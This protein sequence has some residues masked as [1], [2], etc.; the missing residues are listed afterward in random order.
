M[1]S[2]FIIFVVIALIS[3]LIALSITRPIMRLVQSMLE[4]AQGHLDVDIAHCDREDEIGSMN[5]AMVIFRD[6]ARQRIQLEE[7]QS[8]KEAQAE[9]EKCRMMLDIA[10]EFDQ[11]VRTIIDQV[12]HSSVELGKE[13][14]GLASRSREN[15][16]R[17]QSV[18]SA[19]EEASSNVGTVANASEEMSASII[20]ISG[21]MS[22]STQVAHSAFEE[23]QKANEVMS[24]LND[25]SSAIGHIVGLIQEIA[26]QTNLLALNATIEAARAGDAGKGFAVVAVEVKDLALQTGKATEEISGQI[27]AIQS[28]IADAIHAIGRLE[29][30]IDKM[31]AISSTIAAA[32]EEQGI[33]AGEISSNIVQAAAGSRDASENASMMG[34]IASKNSEGAEVMSNNAQA[35]QDQIENLAIQV[36]QF[37]QSIYKQTQKA[38]SEAA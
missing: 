7:Q 13:T 33:A 10:A 26:G 12:R 21:Q 8:L 30:T 9:A 35:L 28:N 19:M 11:T 25:A 16:D 15:T 6:N 31:T 22:E 18:Y 1:S 32:V 3:A 20:E 37:L 36:D 27:N 38:T 23:V 34:Q 2:G 4:L 5:R 29:N 24:N 17:L 14:N